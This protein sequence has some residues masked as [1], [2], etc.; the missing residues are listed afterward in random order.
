MTN[1]T[2]DSVSATYYTYGIE[3]EN[4]NNATISGNTVSNISTTNLGTYRPTG[5]LVYAASTNMTI[6][7]N[8][9]RN[10]KNN[11]TSS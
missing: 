9:I 1:N 4:N 5:I 6:T 11:Y 2:I 7:N 3:M 8:V 10:V